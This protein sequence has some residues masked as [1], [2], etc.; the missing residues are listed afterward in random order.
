MKKEDLLQAIGD[1]GDDLLHMAEHKKFPNYWRKWVPLA[2]CMV[3]VISLSILVLPYFPMGC[4]S[5]MKEEAAMDAAAPEAPAAAPESMQDAAMEESTTEDSADMDAPAAEAPAADE[6]AEMETAEEAGQPVRQDHG[7][8][9]IVY[10]STYYYLSD[11]NAVSS[12]KPADLGEQ[13][14]TVEESNYEELIGHPIYIPSWDVTWFDNHAVDGVTVP[15]CIYV[16][17]DGWYYYG[18]TY[19]EKTVARYTA[20]DVQDA[21]DR[22]DDQ[23][24]IDTFVAPVE[25]YGPI[26]FIEGSHLE[27]DELVKLFYATTYMNTGTQVRI[28]QM[29]DHGWN[30]PFEDLEWRLSRFL[31]DFTFDPDQL[32]EDQLYW[33]NGEAVG[34]SVLDGEMQPQ[35]TDGLYL[36]TAGLEDDQ[37]YLRVGL[38]ETDD[39]YD[40]VHYTIRF[41][42]D[43]WRYES[44]MTPG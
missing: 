10:G 44:I 20:A 42:E 36:K 28:W 26:Y 6:P 3:L 31:Y 39:L 14:G 24:I 41:H 29:K 33:Y 16:E 11:A 7:R 18:E 34:V 27:A 15:Q 19:N 38:P 8:I 9:R 4:G 40:E 30:I 25:M 43:S 12:E 35:P 1:V 23:W 5:S 22:G 2:A 13:I 32:G 21:I 17:V 37:L